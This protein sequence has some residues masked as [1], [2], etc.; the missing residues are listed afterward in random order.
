MHN[1]LVITVT[2]FTRPS[3]PTFTQTQCWCK[4]NCHEKIFRKNNLICSEFT[5]AN[6]QTAYEES[7]NDGWNPD[8][9]RNDPGI[10]AFKFINHVISHVDHQRRHVNL[11]RSEFFSVFTLSD[12]R[13]VPI[14]L[15]QTVDFYDGLTSGP[16]QDYE[17]PKNCNLWRT[18]SS[19]GWAT[20]EI[21]RRRAQAYL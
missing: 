7:D 20:S 21:V 2:T 5:D 19:P 9:Q 12:G 10:N 11:V 15:I 1:Q 17:R 4:S 3:S 8:N 13:E 14:V 16:V 18:S 6:N